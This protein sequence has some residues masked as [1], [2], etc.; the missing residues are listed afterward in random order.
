VIA[1]LLNSRESSIEVVESDIGIQQKD[2]EI[3]CLD[4]TVF[5]INDHYKGV[6]ADLKGVSGNIDTGNYLAAVIAV[7][8]DQGFQGLKDAGCIDNLKD[9][10]TVDFKT[11]QLVLVTVKSTSGTNELIQTNIVYDAKD[12][13]YLNIDISWTIDDDTFVLG[14]ALIVNSSKAVKTSLYLKTDCS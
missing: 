1:T 12:R 2:V 6:S 9:D 13:L 3:T 14:R 5:S 8:D 4:S 7:T 11:Q 10:L